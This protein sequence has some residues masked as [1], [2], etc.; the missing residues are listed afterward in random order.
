MAKDKQNE[1][2]QDKWTFMVYF[3]GDNN[4]SEEMVLALEQIKATGMI[5]D[6]SVLAQFDPSGLG[7][8]TQRYLFSKERW[9]AAPEDPDLEYFRVEEVRDLEGKERGEMNSG[10]PEALSEFITW[11]V[12]SRPAKH[13]AL[14]LSGHGSGITENYLLRDDNPVDSLTIPELR[15]ALTADEL[16]KALKRARG[17]IDILGLDAC[18]MSM[19]EVCSEML[20]AR[21]RILI[22]AEGYEPEFGWPYHR[23]LEASRNRYERTGEH[24]S[25][26][27]LARTIVK[28]YVDYYCDFGRSAG[29]SVDLAAI[30]LS[31]LKTLPK[32]VESLG[33]ALSEAISDERLRDQVLLAHWWAQTFKYDQYVDLADF[34][35]KL[36]KQLE[37]QKLDWD[38]VLQERLGAVSTGVMKSVIQSGFSGFAYQ[39]SHGLSIYF[40]WAVVTDDYSELVHGESRRASRWAKGWLGFLNKYVKETRRDLVPEL[41]AYTGEDVR[42]LESPDPGDPP[43]KWDRYRRNRYRRNRY[44]RNR[45]GARERRV[46]NLAP[47]FGKVFCPPLPSRT[48]EAREKAVLH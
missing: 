23:I 8:A 47:A 27:Q 30:K 34:C 16:Q 46:K 11:A 26:E 12:E 22:G 41:S 7:I 42:E 25:P 21:V 45:A 9:E 29:R 14:V 33:E 38:G 1:R 17:R 6:V 19:F 2:P 15:E 37:A 48:V 3:A 10:S 18:F 39:Y 28:E 36:R 4:L 13:Y 20:K 31:E 44:R 24:Q 43:E 40:P 35:N 32:A 5:P